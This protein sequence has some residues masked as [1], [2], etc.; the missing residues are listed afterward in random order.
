MDDFLKKKTCDRCHGS[1]EKGR[2]MSMFNKD[3]LCITCKKQERNR[4]DYEKARQAEYEA[5]K[6]GNYNFPGIGLNTN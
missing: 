5:V 6:A 4:P 2:S 1:L 3:C